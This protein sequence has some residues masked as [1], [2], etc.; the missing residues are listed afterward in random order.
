MDLN[1]ELKFLIPE[2]CCFSVGLLGPVSKS[3]GGKCQK[4]QY[5]FAQEL[6]I[7]LTCAE[8]CI[9]F[10][11]LQGRCLSAVVFPEKQLFKPGI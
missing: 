1:F 7:Q 6:L 3:A 5:S 8:V 4:R 2:R 9:T 10:L 11:I